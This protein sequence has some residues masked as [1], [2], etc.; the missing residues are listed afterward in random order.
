MNNEE[1]LKQRFLFLS[2]N[3]KDISSISEMH[4]VISLGMLSMIE[5]QLNGD[6]PKVGIA[7]FPNSRIEDS[8]KNDG[9]SANKNI[10][11]T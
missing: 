3:L 5:S 1:S 8:N 10:D 4:G 7:H 2:K 11:I 6:L 9:Y